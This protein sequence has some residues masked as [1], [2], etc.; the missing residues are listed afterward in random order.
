MTQ[1][2][3]FHSTLQKTKPKKTKSQ[4][5]NKNKKSINKRQAWSS[6]VVGRLIPCRLLGGAVAILSA[7]TKRG[8]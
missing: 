3:V 8:I 7:A 2:Q 6:R 5:K 4:T 1:T